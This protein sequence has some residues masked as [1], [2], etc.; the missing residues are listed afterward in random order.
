MVPVTTGVGETGGR[1]VTGRVWVTLEN[2]F[3]VRN[4]IRQGCYV[5]WLEQVARPPSGNSSN[6]RTRAKV[7]CAGETAVVMCRYRKTQTAVQQRERTSRDP[8]SDFSG[9]FFAPSVFSTRPSTRC[10]YDLVPGDSQFLRL[11]AL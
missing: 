9:C 11:N 6:E 3:V 1:E 10:S 8:F 7:R 5:G 4:G 2:R